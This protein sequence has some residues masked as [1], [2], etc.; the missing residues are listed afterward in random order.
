VDSSGVGELGPVPTGA[1]V[2]HAIFDA[3]RARLRE[4]PF[5]PARVKTALAQAAL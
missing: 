5:T 4:I 3:T 2:A 1:A